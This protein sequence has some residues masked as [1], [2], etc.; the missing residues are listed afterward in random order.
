M[1]D[2]Q[3]DLNARNKGALREHFIAPNSETAPT[4]DKAWLQLDINIQNIDD[5]SD[6]KS[7]SKGDY[8]GDGNEV[9]VLTGRAE[10]WKVKGFYTPSNP[11]HKLISRMKRKTNDQE[12]RV[13]HKVIETDGTVVIGKAKILAIKVGGGDA[14]E[15]EPLECEIV[16]DGTPDETLPVEKQAANI[17]TPSKNTK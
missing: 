11:A 7:E 4:D 13:W 1:A 3:P 16:F 2:K 15:Y 9:E 12:R 17:S 8:A 6:E 10:K 5:S 14:T